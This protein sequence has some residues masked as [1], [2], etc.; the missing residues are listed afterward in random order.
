MKICS[1]CMKS[2]L[3]QKPF[4]TPI[5]RAKEFLEKIQSD[6]GGLL[7]PIRWRKQYYI[8]FNGDATEIYYIKTMEY[9]SQAFE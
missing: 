4:Q 3:Q 8:S 1:G 9:K 2:Y 6:L 5:I 7:S